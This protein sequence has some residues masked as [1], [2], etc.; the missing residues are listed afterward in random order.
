MD[1]LSTEV[2][3][4]TVSE[5]MVEARQERE[6]TT[7]ARGN[8][9]E[10][11]S[12]APARLHPRLYSYFEDRYEWASHYLVNGVRSREWDL[13]VDE[14]AESVFVLP[15][16]TET[17]C[18]ELIEEA[19][20]ARCWVSDRHANYPTTDME[21]HQ[22]GFQHIYYDLLQ[23]YV[24][25]LC[26]YKWAIEGRGWDDM[27]TEMFLARYT[28]ETQGHL[29]LHHDYSHMTA[30]LNLSDPAEYEGGGTW[31]WRQK[32]LV[33]SPRG[34]LTIHPG[35]I[36]HRHGARPTT[37]GKRYIVVAFMMNNNWRP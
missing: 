9:E 21:L 7:E 26:I 32:T 6:Y 25:P 27:Y 4:E 33:R 13:L 37:R 16:F 3:T 19:E 22:I 29:G 18:R 23:R 1:Q 36:S 15:F 5:T 31:F 30:L 34:Y 14:P 2:V 28:P 17:F 12:E 11:R 20:H 24:M 35:N 8:V 10:A